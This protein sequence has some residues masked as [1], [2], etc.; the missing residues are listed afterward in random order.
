M[1]ENSHK[2][3]LSSGEEPPVKKSNIGDVLNS[4]P[5][6]PEVTAPRQDSLSHMFV[7]IY[8]SDDGYGIGG[9]ET[10]GVFET[11]EDAENYA[12]AQANDI[13]C[14]WRRARSDSECLLLRSGEDVDGSETLPVERVRFHAKGSILPVP[15]ENEEEVRYL[16]F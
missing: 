16:L 6:R 15:L 13:G 3:T 4:T 14:N 7:V 1:A 5:A 2:R 11:R 12:R 10:R 8:E 9:Q